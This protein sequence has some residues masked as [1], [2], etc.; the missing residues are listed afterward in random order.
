MNLILSH[1]NLPLSELSNSSGKLLSFYNLG[2]NTYMTLNPR[3]RVSVVMGMP[4]LI[5][6]AAET[7]VYLAVS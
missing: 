4:V 1:T 3:V 2:R 7:G 6:V 5:I